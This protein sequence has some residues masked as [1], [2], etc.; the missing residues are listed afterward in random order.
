MKIQVFT[1]IALALIL[2][3]GTVMAVLVV[4]N[5]PANVVK[6]ALLSTFDDVWERQELKTA[7]RMTQRGSL[8]IEA[9]SPIMPVAEG[10][11][12]ALSGKLYFSKDALMIEGLKVGGEEPVLSGDIYL[13]QDMLYLKEDK[14]LEGAF[15][16]QLSEL[17]DELRN[18]IFAYDSGSA[19]ALD[20]DTFNELMDLIE[21][22]DEQNLAQE[23]RSL[24]N[25]YTKKLW[26]LLCEHA[27]FV[28]EKAEVAFD[29]Q[30]ETVRVVTVTLDGEGLA[31]IIEQFYEYM[32]ADEAMPAFLDSYEKQLAL[33]ISAVDDSLSLAYAEMIA[34]MEEGI[35]SICTVIREGFD[36]LTLKVVTPKHKS[37]LLR[38]SLSYGEE[39]L[40]A[41]DFGKEG[42]KKTDAIVIELYGME[43]AYRITQN[44]SDAY[45]AALTVAQESLLDVYVDRKTESYQL[46][47]NNGAIR[48]TVKG[49]VQNKHGDVTVTVK[50]VT[51]ED[52]YF[53]ETYTADVD[54]TLLMRPYDEIPAAPTDYK[55]LSEITEADIEALLEK[56]TVLQ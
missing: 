47:H 46:T 14:M 32:V 16:V 2:A 26:Q 38:C 30:K 15:G 50:E 51:F 11:G 18:S 4:D 56:L 34:Q 31:Q 40:V 33:F 27:E 20:E 12:G 9:N 19:L 7:Y 5:N 53:E 45:K 28:S 37:R 22:I 21:T 10:E 42:I 24:L 13:S 55:K 25:Q 8:Q 6:E 3:G 44:D 43:I 29:E 52:V 48:R 39:T 1:L 41:V 54:I 49:K 36:T 23:A 17:A 35:E